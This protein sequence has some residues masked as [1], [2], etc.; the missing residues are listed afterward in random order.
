MNILFPA[1]Y[2]NKRSADE[3]FSDQWN[4][5]KAAGF[6]CHTLDAETLS[7]KSVTPSLPE[8]AVVLYRGYMLSPDQYGDLHRSIAAL[9]ATMLTG[10]DQ[11]ALCHYIPNWYSLIREYTPETVFFPDVDAAIAGIEQLSWDGFFIK[12]YVKSLKTSL[13][14]QIRDRSQ[15]LDVVA[16]MKKF[17]GKIEG[18]LSI[19]RIEQLKPE[20]ERRVFIKN[21]RAYMPDGSTPPQ[22]IEQVAARIAAPFFSVDI[23]ENDAGNLRVVE[24][25]DGQVSDIV[26]WNAE[27]FV[28]IFRG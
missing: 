16:E 14:S 27:A 1:D 9:G 12:D 24:I 13:G 20:T 15:L 11:Y 10:P 18:G 2:F 17:R 28:K 6:S 4:A 7:A 21:G 25:G 26:G 23:I 19:R 8:G 5:F 22:I 3:A